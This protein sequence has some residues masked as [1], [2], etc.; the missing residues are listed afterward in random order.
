M[1][2][3]SK[4]IGSAIGVAAALALS[5]STTQAANILVDPGFESGAFGQLNPIPLPGGVDGGW[6]GFNGAVYANAAAETGSWG[7]Q[8]MQGIGQ[9]WNFMAAYQVVGGVSAGQQYTLTADFMTPTGITEAAGGAYIPAVIQ[10]TYF[11][12]AGTDLGT[13]ETGGVGARAIQYMPGAA[14]VWYSG[15]VTATAPAGAVYVAP[16]LAFM[17][18]GSQT[19][20]D[21]LYWDNASL[22]L[23]PE[24]SS[25]ALL[26][27]GLGLPFYFWRRRNS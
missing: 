4:F 19:A 12:A 20:A 5:I 10:L 22:T 23:V 3:F 21:T 11:N 16:Y 8:E 6:A 18:N 25:L 2:K 17:E 9:A 14:N 24:P 1:K 26:G 27:M 15:A 13:V 7:L